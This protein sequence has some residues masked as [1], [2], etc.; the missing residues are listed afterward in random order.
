M[1]IAL[2]SIEDLSDFVADDDLVVEP[3]KRLGY[4]AEFV[5][6]QK[7]VDWRNYKGVIIRT[8]WDYQNHLASFLSVLKQIET[9][10]QLANPLEIVKWNADKKIYL[11]DLE[12]RGARIVPTLWN[13][14]KIDSR[15]IQQWFDQLQ[16]DEIVIKPTIG[17]NA[18]D[19]W[20]LKRG[21]ED[22]DAL[23]RVFDSRSCMVQPFMRGIVEEGEFSLFYFDGEY[24]H[25]ILK[26]PKPEDFRVQEEHGGRIQ[27]IQAPINSATTG[28][29]ILKCVSPSPLYARVDLVRTEDGGFAL[30]ELEL[31]EPSLYLRM[32]EYAPA[33]FAKAIKRWLSEKR[34][35]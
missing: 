5:A 22:V 35:T 29:E 23:A 2:L 34:T 21:K 4:T 27:A 32:A 9:Q 12:A 10:T 28:E 3:L 13:A 16:T 31:I 30:V 7:P 15:L 6:W 18:Q 17:A 8:T 26:T 24:S 33:L 20:R 1:R 11:R 14:G 19:A 25:A